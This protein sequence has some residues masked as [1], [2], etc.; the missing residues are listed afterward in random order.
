M[1]SCSRF[2]IVLDSDVLSVW[3]GRSM[4]T[5][6]YER[7]TK[8]RDYSSDA[9]NDVRTILQAATATAAAAAGSTAAAAATPAAVVT[10]AAAGAATPAVIAQRAESDERLG[11]DPRTLIHMHGVFHRWIVSCPVPRV[12]RTGSWRPPEVHCGIVR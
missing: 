4:S 11:C 6:S 3:C 8:E 1:V 9:T 12:P 7:C 5:A 10:P 2:S